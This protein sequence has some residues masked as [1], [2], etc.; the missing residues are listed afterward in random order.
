MKFKILG[1]LL[2][3]IILFSMIWGSFSFL[4]ALYSPEFD[5]ISI[6]THIVDGDTFDIDTG[7]RIRLADVDTPEKNEAG[8]FEAYQFLSNLIYNKKVYL[9]IDDIYVYDKYGRLVCLVYVDYN[10]THYLNINKA[11]LEKDLALISNYDNEFNP[12]NW[13]LYT[14][15]LGINELSKILIASFFIGLVGTILFYLI[16]KNVGRILIS[17]YRGTRKKLNSLY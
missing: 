2:F 9:D 15:K 16:F 3:S 7:Q 8:Y 10:S 17:A 6:A 12:K 14:P 4:V 11:L 1:G 13:K 5:K